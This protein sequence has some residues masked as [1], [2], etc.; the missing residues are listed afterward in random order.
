MDL[1]TVKDAAEKLQITVWRVHQLIKGGR[2]PAQ[3]LGSQ[4]VIQKADLKLVADRKPGR[5]V[6]AS[7]KK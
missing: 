5:P 6:M 2:I 3:K 7:V 1:L 4:Y